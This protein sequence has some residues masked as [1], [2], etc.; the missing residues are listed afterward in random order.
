M[1]SLEASGARTRIRIRLR[2]VN[3][4]IYQQLYIL[5]KLQVTITASKGSGSNF[6]RATQLETC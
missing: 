5:Q 1:H 4:H 6:V 3:R 2:I